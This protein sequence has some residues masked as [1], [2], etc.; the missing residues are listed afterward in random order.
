MDFTAE[1]FQSPRLQ[2]DTVALNSISSGMSGP[3]TMWWRNR[4]PGSSSVDF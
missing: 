2:S 4:Q 1:R 3:P